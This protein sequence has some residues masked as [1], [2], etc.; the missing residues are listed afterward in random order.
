MSVKVMSKVW[1]SAPYSGG[2]L[3][4]LLALADW[5][6]DEG[7]CYPKLETVA[8]KARLKKSGAKYCMKRLIDDKAV[9]LEEE[10][11][12]PGKPRKYRIGVQY[13]DPSLIQGV[14]RTEPK[15]VSKPH[16]KG[17]SKPMRNKEE[18]SLN[19]QEQ[20]PS[21]KI[22]CLK[23]NG[24]GDYPVKAHPGRTAYCECEEGRRL[25]RS[26]RMAARAGA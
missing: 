24:A 13:L 23:C 10:S 1:H 17:S 5:A 18:P 14:Q 19:H 4:V 6:D 25:M 11:D 8:K 15:G 7:R 21:A 20:N 12:G 16:K 22:V 9:F 2:T 26:E 3:L